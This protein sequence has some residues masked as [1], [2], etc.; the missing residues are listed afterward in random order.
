MDYT[1]LFDASAPMPTSSREARGDTLADRRDGR[2]YIYTDEIELAVNIALATG[3]PMLV[4]GPSGTGK[5][6]LARNVALRLKRRYYEYVITSKSQHSDLEY[7]FD[8]LRRFRDAQLGAK[9][10]RDADYVEPR[11]LWWAFDPASA[12]RRGLPEN[13]PPKTLA[14]DP[15]PHPGEQ[16]VVLIDEIDK[17]DPDVPNN[18]LVTLGS[19]QFTIP[20]LNDRTVTTAAAPLIVITSNDER[21]LPIAFLRRCTMLELKPPTLARLVAIAAEHFGASAAQRKSYELVAQALYPAGGNAPPSTAEYLDAIRACRRLGV[22]P[23]EG[24][25]TW[26]GVVRAT[27]RKPATPVSLT[28]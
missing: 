10:L 19:L 16:A 21:D 20:F 13:A 6:S 2:I 23:K 24:D 27:V 11:A 15:S 28:T 3:R 14:V 18:L 7:H 22:Q 1:K 25:E 17:A 4:R 26:E 8:L 12:S 5:S 9:D